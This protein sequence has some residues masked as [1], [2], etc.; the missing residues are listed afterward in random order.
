MN[1]VITRIELISF[2]E[3]IELLKHEINY[4]WVHRR[5]N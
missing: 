5:G 4:E 2:I 3:V 1:E